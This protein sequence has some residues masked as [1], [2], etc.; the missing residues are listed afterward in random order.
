MV[1][2]IN[3]RPTI[4]HRSI[5]RTCRKIQIPAQNPAT[6]HAMNTSSN[7]QTI[8]KR[9]FL[10]MIAVRSMILRKRYCGCW[11]IYVSM[12]QTKNSGCGTMMLDFG[13]EIFSHFSYH[14]NMNLRILY[15]PYSYMDTYHKKRNF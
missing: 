5:T 9:K 10:P 1:T 6:G 13:R 8:P 14:W 3:D 11:E 2:T 7:S 4:D 15:N 12:I